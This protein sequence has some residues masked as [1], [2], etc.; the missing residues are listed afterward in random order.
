M[1]EHGPLANPQARRRNKRYTS[2]KHVMVARPH[3][4]ATL[5]E[6]AKAEWKRVVPELE[7][8]GLLTKVDRGAL[9]RYCT[10][11]ADWV[12]LDEKLQ[13]T[14]KLI[15]G[16]RDGLVRNPLWLMR[17]DALAALADLGKQLGLTSTARLRLGIEHDI[18]DTADRDA[19]V[20][21]IDEYRARLSAS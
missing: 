9:I 20:T 13:L 10:V 7:Q 15:K 4:P 11:W 2:G 19:E 21:A 5:T 6:E 14:G 3:M 18:P 8:M 17:N 16:R 1:G 12:D